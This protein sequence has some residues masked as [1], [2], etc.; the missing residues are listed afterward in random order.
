MADQPIVLRDEVKHALTQT[1][2]FYDKELSPVQWN[3]W[4]AALKHLPHKNC[5]RALRD[6][7]GEGKYAPRP[8]HIVEIANRYPR[9][10]Y[11]QREAAPAPVK[12]CP[13]EI[14]QAWFWYVGL[15]AQGSN[16]EG[17][18][19]HTMVDPKTEE[20]YLHIVNHEAKANNQPD[21]ILPEHR[22]PEVWG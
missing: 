22:L 12:E 17:L 3:F 13:R 16:L 20:R 4:W 15:S 11:G 2:A 1:L 21:A 10:G 5:M 7:V 19:G 8:A 9:D 6:Y 14:A 18:F